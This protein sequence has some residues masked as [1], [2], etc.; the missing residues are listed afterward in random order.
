[1]DIYLPTVRDKLGLGKICPIFQLRWVKFLGQV[2]VSQ[3]ILL[4]DEG[5]CISD[6]LKPIVG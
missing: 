4:N 3:K 1:M 2:I 5:K 6:V